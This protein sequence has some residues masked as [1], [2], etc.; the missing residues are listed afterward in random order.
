MIFDAVAAGITTVVALVLAAGFER[1]YGEH[2]QPYKMW[3]AVSFLVTALATALQLGAFIHRGFIPATYEAYVILAAAIPGLMGIGSLYLLWP[4]IAPVFTAVILA[5]VVVTGI[6]TFVS[7]LHPALLGNVLKASQEVTQV[8]P[9]G[10]VTL[11][12]A[13]L[14]A[15]GAGAMV[16]GALWSWWRRRELYNLGIAVGAIVFSLADTLAA[17][18]VPALF[19][20]AEVVG[21]VVLYGS[22]VKSRSPEARTAPAARPGA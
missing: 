15:L 20:L 4:R 9:N 3:W 14:G 18:G 12:F 21:I 22:V 16:V 11:G 1:S 6:G 10:L 13:V 7:P 8:L 19:Y 17:Y 5:A 2:P